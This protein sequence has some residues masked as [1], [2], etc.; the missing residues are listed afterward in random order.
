MKGP[1]TKQAPAK[2]AAGLA[3]VWGLGRFGG[4]L[5][6]ARF[7][8]RRGLR[9]RV[10]DRAPADNL[11]TS[12]QELQG[13]QG[14][15]WCLGSEDPQHV[16][17]ADLVIVNPAIPDHHP[18]LQSI[19]RM[20][21]PRAQEIELFLDAYPGDVVLV[22]GTNG[23]S[24]TASLLHRCLEMSGLQALLGG[25]IGHSLLEDE[26]AWDRHPIA[27]VEISSFQL[28][29]LDR[30][31][32]RRVRGT[33]LTTIGED[34]L[35][36]HGSLQ[37]YRAAKAVAAS[38]AEEFLVHDA[39]DPVAETFRSP[40][41]QRIRISTTAA[42]T[43]GRS[44]VEDGW[45]CLP[46][47]AAQPRLL[48]G[49]ALPFAG[50]P[51]QLNALLAGTAAW[52]LGAQPERIGIALASAQPLPHRLQLC[53]THRGVQVF[54]NG[55]S[56]SA[57]ST[58]AALDSIHR[59][60]PVAPQ[61]TIHWVGGG[62]SKG[63]DL[64]RIAA[65]LH[66]ALVRVHGRGWLFGA[67]ANPLRDAIASHGRGNAPLDESAGPAGW[68]RQ[69]ALPDAPPSRADALCT[70]FP[71]LD[72]AL[73]AA[74]KAAQPGD[75]VL[76]SPGFAS[77]DAYANFKARAAAFHRILQRWRPPEGESALDRAPWPTPEE[78]ES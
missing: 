22:T 47:R 19:R 42:P 29:R 40:A 66:G 69:A 56:T 77:F 3:V 1:S 48:H 71:S 46:T 37:S 28:S 41:R 15:E 13:D 53:V 12:V 9:V 75:V 26:D 16:E 6:A 4:G 34:H 54:D 14:I 59:G 50:R 61:G 64:I 65:D 20:G 21:I 51:Q 68:H 8:R 38:L 57:S 7:L 55:V 44:G 49:D 5:G 24:T 39:G 73:Q 10:L 67:V 36:R 17:G 11:A 30:E 23:K 31:R 2:G 70:G 35:D 63:E 43:A 76:F 78:A 45:L 58:I 25:N 18:L 60:S 52:I 74:L 72:E 33:V 27:L 32:I 62:A